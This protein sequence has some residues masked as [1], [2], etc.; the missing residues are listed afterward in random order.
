[1]IRYSFE[2]IFVSRPGNQIVWLWQRIDMKKRLF[3]GFFFVS[4]FP[5]TIL[6]TVIGISF[7]QKTVRD[8]KEQAI[9][10]SGEMQYRVEGLM[11]QQA[12]VLD[13]FASDPDIVKTIRKMELGAGG[14]ENALLEQ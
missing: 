13:E 11:G 2:V 8:Y 7:Y 6:F 10:I 12:Q 3:I 1:M 14:T 5:A 9:Q 4:V